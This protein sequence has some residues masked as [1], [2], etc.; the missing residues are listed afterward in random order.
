MSYYLYDWKSGAS[1]QDLQ[2]WYLAHYSRRL[3]CA[4]S[5]GVP[6]Q[7]LRDYIFNL[8]LAKRA[9]LRV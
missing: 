3:E 9:T 1:V 5:R 8:R 2:N 7:D 4:I 6:C